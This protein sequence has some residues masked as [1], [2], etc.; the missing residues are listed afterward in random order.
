MEVFRL[1]D[2]RTAVAVLT[3]AHTNSKREIIRKAS[4]LLVSN[5][6][7]PSNVGGLDRSRIGVVFL[8]VAS[9]SQ[10]KTAP[11]LPQNRQITALAES[12][13][14][15]GESVLLFRD[16]AELRFKEFR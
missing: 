9:I 13:E 5:A 12:F 1:S 2:G 6:S 11:P 8:W 3:R 15:R 10:V 4:G 7:Y 14:Q 16:N